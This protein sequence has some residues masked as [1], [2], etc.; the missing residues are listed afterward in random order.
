MATRCQVCFERVYILL[1]V[2]DVPH[3]S[4]CACICTFKAL[5][6]RARSLHQQTVQSY[7]C[8]ELVCGDSRLLNPFA[9]SSCCFCCCLQFENSNDVGELHMQ[10]QGC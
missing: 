8:M 2:I 7:Q 5:L 6:L 3:T 4:P 10:L 9:L 1:C